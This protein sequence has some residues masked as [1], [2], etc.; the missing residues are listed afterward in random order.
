MIPCCNILQKTLPNEIARAYLGMGVLDSRRPTLPKGTDL[1]WK[2]DAN[3]TTH[4]S[5]PLRSIE[6]S[7]RYY[8]HRFVY[9]ARRGEP[10]VAE[11]PDG[12]SWRLLLFFGVCE[13]VLAGAFVPMLRQTT[14]RWSLRVSRSELAIDGPTLCGRSELRLMRDQIE[15]VTAH[16]PSL[17]IW[18]RTGRTGPIRLQL[19]RRSQ[20]LAWIAETIRHEMDRI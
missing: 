14:S 19:R 8:H 7:R 20:D 4:A 18:K 13:L 11:H 2:K 10:G 9:N 15:D 12:N 6:G 1:V 17:L 16:S 5:A 3:A